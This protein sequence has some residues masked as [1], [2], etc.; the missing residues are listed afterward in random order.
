MV[1]L[2]DELS[3]SLIEDLASRCA[4]EGALV[5]GPPEKVA[6]AL[7]G[8]EDCALAAITPGD[9]GQSPEAIKE[10]KRRCG[11]HVLL[12]LSGK[13]RLAAFPVPR[14]RTFE[15]LS[16]DAPLL[17]AARTGDELSLVLEA[18]RRL[19]ELGERPRLAILTPI[20]ECPRSPL[21]VCISTPDAEVIA[22]AASA[23]LLPGE[24][25]LA[26]HALLAAA[27]H[28][29]PS[30]LVGY[31]ELDERLS[32]LDV[33]RASASPEGVAEALLSLYQGYEA[34][35]RG[36]RELVHQVPDLAGDAARLC[37]LLGGRGR[38]A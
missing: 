24:S 14:P 23:A 38:N 31:G 4:W 29:R 26:D 1:C 30:I 15:P 27:A 37:E 16:Q 3:C 22:W 33:I 19:W 8:I 9:E 12:G 6:R 25:Y 7:R 11:S 10:A 21:I 34:R 35:R 13:G 18:V 5:V 2:D 32:G 17:V 28:L 36:E 20:E